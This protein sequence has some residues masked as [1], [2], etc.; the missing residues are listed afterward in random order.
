MSAGSLDESLLETYLRESAETPR[1]SAEDEAQL[2]RQ[3]VQGDRD[4]H[5]RMVRA[6]LDLVVTVARRYQD[7]GLG[8]KALLDVGNVGLIRA[9]KRYDPSLGHRFRTYATWWIRQSITRVLYD[10]NRLKQE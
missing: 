1:L 4:A 3:I 5:H 9:A 2:L 10:R 6:N 7:R 8:L